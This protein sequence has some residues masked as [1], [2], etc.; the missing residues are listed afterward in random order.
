VVADKRCNGWKSSSLAASE[1]LAG[2]AQRFSDVGLRSRELTELAALTGWHRAAERTLSV[3]RAI[4][5]RLP[6]DARL[7]LRERDFVAPD[8]AA[9]RDALDVPWV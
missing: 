3:G 4:Y 6:D 1:H 9:I 8:M 2:W 5:L 7:W